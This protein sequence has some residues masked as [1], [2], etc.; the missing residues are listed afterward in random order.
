MV[1]FS[2]DIV[3]WSLGYVLL[4]LALGI[5]GRRAMRERTLSDF[6]LAGRNIG[7]FVLILTLFAT[8]YSGNSMSGFPG[9]T[10][11]RGLSYMMSVTFMIGIVAGYTLFAPR[12]FSIA[13]R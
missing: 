11:R 9:Q 1:D 12:L 2:H 4:L 5:A 7:F 3:W 10:Y 6:Y 13:R 8:Q